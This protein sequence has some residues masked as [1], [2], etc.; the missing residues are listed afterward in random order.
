MAIG[1]IRALHDNG[2]RVPR[3][4]SVMGFDGLPLS[5]F[6]VPQ[7]S[8]VAQSM[9]L[10]AQRSVAILIDRI[11][12]GGEACHESVPYALYQRESTRRVDE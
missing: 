2:L 8:T 4:V 11:E 10:M 6:L 1:A 9:R 5:S 3:D 12:H 7:L